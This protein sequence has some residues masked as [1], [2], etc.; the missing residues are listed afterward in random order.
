MTALTDLKL[1]Y[2]S[3]RLAV[4]LLWMPHSPPSICW[5]SSPTFCISTCPGVTSEGFWESMQVHGHGPQVMCSTLT[6]LMGLA[7]RSLTG[8]DLSNCHA[9]TLL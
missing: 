6:S 7:L 5:P 9:L 2:T 4:H 1:E 8:L 3:A